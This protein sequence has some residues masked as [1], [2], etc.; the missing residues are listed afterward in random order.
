LEV[1]AGTWSSG[2]RP[3]VGQ[4][5]QWEGF[6][7]RETQN[8]V[9]ALLTA[10]APFNASDA[11]AANPHEASRA[12][13]LGYRYLGNWQRRANNRC[14]EEAVLRENLRQRGYSDAH[15]AAALLKLLLAVEV[16]GTSAH[17]AKEANQ[18]TY[19]LLRY[20]VT[21]CLAAGQPHETVHLIDWD[22]PERNDFALA[23]EVTL[24]GDGHERRP[25]LVV[26]LNGLVVAVMELKR[27]TV[28]VMEGVRQLITNQEHLFNQGFFSTVQWLVAGNESQGVRLGTTGASEK[29]FVQWKNPQSTP[30]NAT[31]AASSQHQEHHAPGAL[32]DEPLAYVFDKARLLDVMRH[33]IIFDAGTKKVP[34]PHQYLG[35]KAA[36][37]RIA[38]REGGVIWHTQGSGKS[39]LMVLLAKWLLE[40]D[41][42]ARILVVTDRDELDRQMEGVMRN[43]GVISKE[44]ASPRI[45]SRR[46]LVAKLASTTP[47][48]MCALLHKFEPNDMKGPPPA[49]AGRFHV[50]VDECHRSQGGD[51]NQQMKRWLASALFIGFSGT[52]LLLAD[53]P[54]TCSVFGT[55]IH[56]YKYDE[57]VADGV[58]LDL[59][60]EARTVPQRL[61]SRE[62]LD[63]WF[64]VKTRGLNNYQKSVLRKRWATLESLMSS[65]ERKRRIVA[66]I[67][68]DFGTKPRLNNDR[69]TAIL[70]AA[71]IYDACHYLR[72]FQT[73]LMGKHCGIVTSFEPNASAIA[74]QAADSDE[75]YKFDTY[76]QHVLARGQ[77]TGAYE[78]QIKRRFQQEP[79]N[80]KLLVVV[81][82][83][84]TGFDAPS[85]TV[86][87][88]DNKL[89]DHN[90]FQAIC[91]TNRL[92]GDDKK[93]GHIV[94][95]KELYEAV[96]KSLAVYTSS[97]LEVDADGQD[98][99]VMLKDWLD[100]GK[101]QL[102]TALEA[103]R[104]LCEPVALPRGIEQYLSSFC[105]A[106]VSDAQALL[107]TEPLRVVFYK[108]ATT[109]MRAYADVAQSLPDMVYS[110]E[111]AL[112]LK[113]EVAFYVEARV[114]IKKHS[115][116]E[117]DV[118]PFEGDMRHLINTYIQAD[119]AEKLGDMGELTLTQLIVQTGV[120]DAI[121]QKLNSKG[122]LSNQAVAT[123]VINNLRQTII[124]EQLSDP[125]FY[126]ELSKLLNDLIAHKRDDTESYAGFLKQAEDLARKLGEKNQGKGP[127][128]LQGKPEALRRVYSNWAELVAGTPFVDLADE[129]K[130]EVVLNIDQ[131]LREK[132]PAGWRGDD[133]REREVL[134]ALFP[135]L[136]RN[137]PA[138]QAIF[139]FLKN[140]NAY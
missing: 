30:T 138:T 125:K 98:G 46:E 42:E 60:Y 66:D 56:T 49:V 47:R 3:R 48:L 38:Q 54:T 103:M 9:V 40:H 75:R 8:R 4:L 106:N 20:G 139:D 129:A 13:G 136:E 55:F 28:N 36:Q 128:E 73:T 118:K 117:L 35:L 90:L 37:A 96:Q 110:N 23:E 63:E 61:G 92:D 102:E 115:G 27:S 59:T 104:H 64:E 94:D 126:A 65:D 93:F 69:G 97:E 76:T 26:Y 89:R 58:V 111:A 133:V 44:A 19:Q 80:M 88:L 78:Q 122:Q 67:V 87:Y 10:A 135:V 99:N 53:K 81:S 18:R 137:R 45:T 119:S 113:A 25:D 15:M 62:Q 95:Y 33:F 77:S 134:N 124:R 105:G 29:Y 24:N 101:N 112:A 130:L 108:T 123:G 50:L 11:K 120:N 7:W 32:L 86:I 43:A 6:P 39:I 52:P 1:K 85:C 83:L 116:E 132:A 16:R 14:V 2:A 71:S 17:D 100:V 91:R 82:K 5:N 68:H 140:Q 41:P 131:T 74:N 34:R 51:M 127:R 31:A 107:D 57:A 21:V 121:A 12:H 79:A 22:H 72:L 84:L 114:A 109:L 70:V